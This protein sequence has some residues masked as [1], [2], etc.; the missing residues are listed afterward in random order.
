MNRKQ[1]IE[2]VGAEYSW[3]YAWSFLRPE[4]RTVIFAAWDVLTDSGVT[5]ILSQD[6]EY[7]A[8]GRASG[9]FTWSRN[10]IRLVEDGGW[11]L[12]VFEQI[13][14]FERPNGTWTIARITPQLKACRLVRIRDSWF[15]VDPNAEV[16]QIPEELAA[17]E[18]P[19]M[20]EG[21]KA[22]ITV[23]AYE[24][25]PEARAA[26]I[27]H[28]G[29]TCAVC[30]FN[31]GQVYGAWGE[32]YIHAHHL[33][34]VSARGGTYKVDPINDMVPLCANCHSMVHRR[35]GTLSLEELRSLMVVAT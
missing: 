20:V 29:T 22:Q 10:H 8:S 26:C 9:K 17:D 18:L 4:T 11:D 27:A 1:F 33:I 15:A 34:P 7:E 21:A 30:G 28:H 5:E 12:Q 3:S 19:P 25:S 32:G 16:S 13:K 31:F 2:S 6:W 14:G 24:R 35:R 23:N